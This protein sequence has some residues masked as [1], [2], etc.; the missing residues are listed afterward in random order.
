MA[1]GGVE[2]P[3]SARTATEQQIPAVVPGRRKTEDDHANEVVLRHVMGRLQ[4]GGFTGQIVLHINHG[5]IRKTEHRDFVTTE[6]LLT[7]NRDG[8]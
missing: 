3:R 4:H 6:A 1:T 5:I 8:S 7:E 2:G